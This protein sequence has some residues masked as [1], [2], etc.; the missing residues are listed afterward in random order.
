MQGIECKTSWALG[1]FVPGKGLS[2]CL[3]ASLQDSTH[4]LRENGV[5]VVSCSW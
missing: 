2:F 1:A 4:T 3:L 5:G